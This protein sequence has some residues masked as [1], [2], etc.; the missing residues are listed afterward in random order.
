MIAQAE[1]VNISREV[2]EHGVIRAAGGDLRK[3]I[4]YM[5]SAHRLYSAVKDGSGDFGVEE[6]AGESVA[7][8]A[9]MIAD[10]AGVCIIAEPV[11]H[12]TIYVTHTHSSDH[13]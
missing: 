7:I 9:E 8:T 12:R 11:F 5:Q 4:T 1:R 6:D 10:I 3:A 13:S 2:L